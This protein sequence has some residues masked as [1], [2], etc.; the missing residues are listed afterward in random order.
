LHNYWH[1]CREK[2]DTAHKKDLMESWSIF[3]ETYEKK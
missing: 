2:I 3:S 1:R